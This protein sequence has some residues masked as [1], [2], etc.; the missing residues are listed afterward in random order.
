MSARDYSFPYQEGVFDLAVATSVFTHLLPD[1]VD[2]Y[3]A[4]S[5]RVLAP[6]GRLFAT[7]FLLTAHGA[8]RSDSLPFRLDERFSPAAIVDRD[9][10]EAAVAYPDPWLRDRL[11]AHGLRPRE[12]I[13]FGSWAGVPGIS[14]QDLIVAER[15]SGPRF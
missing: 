13:H 1:A 9:V 5:A 8:R 12:P 10:P 7:W 14:Y 6:S 3:L 2:R 4:E 11:M 15:I